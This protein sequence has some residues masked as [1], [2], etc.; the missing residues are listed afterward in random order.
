MLTRNSDRMLAPARGRWASGKHDR[1]LSR[2]SAGGSRRRQGT[3]ARRASS[4]R[5]SS[6]TFERMADQCG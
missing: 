2:H 6:Q 5:F 1:L 3:S 4:G